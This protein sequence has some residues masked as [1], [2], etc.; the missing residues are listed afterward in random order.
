MGAFEDGTSFLAGVLAKLPDAV[1]AQVKDVFDKPEAKDAVTLLGDSVLARTDYS[2]HMDALR[3]E[4]DTLTT[5]FNELNTWYDRNKSALTEYPTLK[6]E[7]DRLKAGGTG[8][9]DD[10]DEGKGKK[11]AL[12]DL[13]TVALEVVNSAAPEYIAVSAWL[14]SKTDQ[15][16]AMFGEPLDAVALVRNPKLGKDIAGQPGRVYSLDDAYT[17][18][19]GDRVKAKQ[20]EAEDKRINDKV[21]ARL[22]EERAKLVGQPF[23][24]RGEASPSVLDVLQTKEGPAVHTLDSA[25]AE[26]ERLQA[27]RSVG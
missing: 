26:Y 2:K 6:A 12:P 8:D 10:P 22:K 7:L 5:K 27:A 3:V 14:A 24:L 18:T 9:D 17:E 20:Q 15:H 4:K 23:P 25:T 11:P 21:E 1:R 16:R 13:R 19:F